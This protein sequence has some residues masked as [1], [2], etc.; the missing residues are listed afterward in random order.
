VAVK[1]DLEKTKDAFKPNHG[2]N[3]TRPTP[4]VSCHPINIRREMIS[5]I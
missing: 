2:G 3:L 5:K 4:T 1:K